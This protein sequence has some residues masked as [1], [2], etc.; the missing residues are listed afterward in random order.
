MSPAKPHQIAE[1]FTQPVFN[2]RDPQA[3]RMKQSARDMSY[4]NVV[5]LFGITCVFLPIVFAIAWRNPAYLL[6]LAYLPFALL[7]SPIVFSFSPV[8]RRMS[9]AMHFMPVLILL[10]PIALIHR[11]VPSPS[12]YIFVVPLQLI[13]SWCTKRELPG[14]KRREWQGFSRVT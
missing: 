4:D 8:N 9:N 5:R 10:I 3:L 13:L 6:Q 7:I 1:D 14:M 11:L 12:W 2:L